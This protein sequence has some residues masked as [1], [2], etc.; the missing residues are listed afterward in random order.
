MVIILSML[1]YQFILLYHLILVFNRRQLGLFLGILLSLMG[2]IILVTVKESIYRVLVI[3]IQ[4]CFLVKARKPR[5]TA[6]QTG[7]VD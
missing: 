2:F 5:G 7:T 4:V 3:I 6:D 1:K